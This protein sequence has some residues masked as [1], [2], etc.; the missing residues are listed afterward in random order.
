M[1]KKSIPHVKNIIVVAS[2][3]GGVGKSTTALNL[4]VSLHQKGLRVG[5]LDADIYGPSLPLMVGCWDKPEVSVDKKLIPLE[6]YGLSLM[7]MGFLIERDKPVIWRGPMVQGALQQ[8]L[9]EVAWGHEGEL[10]VL[11]IDTPPGTGDV[12]LSLAQQLQVDGA[13]VVSTPQDMA[14]IDAKK[15][16]E[17]FHKVDIPVIGLIENMAYFCCPNCGVETDIF[18]RYGVKVTAEESDISFLGS[19]PLTLSIRKACDDGMPV[20]LTDDSSVKMYN[21]IGELI[22]AKILA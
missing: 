13:I 3:K 17:M 6:K 8:L 15:A 7:S 20:G 5:L 2:G 4:A 12:H 18:N 14:L 19:I 11:V 9:F 16:I 10:D 1:I 22:R 21:Q